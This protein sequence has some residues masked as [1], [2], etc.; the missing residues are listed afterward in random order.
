MAQPKKLKDVSFSQTE[1]RNVVNS[2][3]KAAC[4]KDADYETTGEYWS[5]VYRAF[6]RLSNSKV[7]KTMEQIENRFI[8]IAKE[9]SKYAAFWK[10]I[11]N[12]NL[13]EGKL[14]TLDDT[15]LDALRWWSAMN[16]VEQKKADHRKNHPNRPEPKVLPV[17]DENL[18][19]KEGPIIDLWLMLNETPLY[20][21]LVSA[22]CQ[23]DWTPHHLKIENHA[24]TAKKGAKPERRSTRS[25]A[26]SSIEPKKS[27]SKYAARQTRSASGTSRPV[28][29]KPATRTTGRSKRTV[30][31]P[32]HESESGGDD[33]SSY[34]ASDEEATSDNSEPTVAKGSQRPT[35]SSATR[36][37]ARNTRARLPDTTDSNDGSA[38]ARN[39]NRN[40]QATSHTSR[41]TSKRKA[42]SVEKAVKRPSPRKRVAPM[43]RPKAV[44][45]PAVEKR[46]PP[47][48]QHEHADTHTSDESK[49]DETDNDFV[50]EAEHTTNQQLYGHDVPRQHKGRR[51][52]EL[53]YL[54]NRKKIEILNYLRS[55]GS[56]EYQRCHEAYKAEM[57]KLF[58][59][60]LETSSPTPTPQQ[61]IQNQAQS[62]K[63]TGQVQANGVP[64]ATK[65]EKFWPVDANEDE[66]VTA[67]RQYLRIASVQPSPDYTPIAE[68]LKAQALHIG[69]EYQ[70]HTLVE[71]KPIIVLT[72]KG[73]NP[74]AKSVLLNS[75][76]DVVPVEN[77]KWT[78]PPFDAHKDAAGRIYA[79]GA[80]DMKCVGVQYLY[81]IKNLLAN[82]TSTQ[83]LFTRTLHISFVPDEEIGG[84]DGM[85][86]FCATQHFRNLNV[87]FALD[88]GLASA[89]ERCE[90]YVGE[91]A[92]FWF[93][94][95]AAGTPGHGSLFIENTASMRLLSVLQKFVNLRNKNDAE[96]KAN[97]LTNGRV[98]SV[99]I[100]KINGGVQH[101]V[102]PSVMTAAVDIRAPPNVTANDVHNLIDSYLEEGVTATY[103]VN[104]P[105]NKLTAID[106]TNPWWGVFTSA[107][108]EAGVLLKEPDIFP[109]GTDSRFLRAMGIPTVGFSPISN[110]PVLLHDHDEYLTESTY[111][112]GVRAYERII[113]ALANANGSTVA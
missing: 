10:L 46:I 28:S 16:I 95:T 107:C 64:T 93:N 88:E 54:E 58:D 113:S 41:R 84:A 60:P 53:S 63:S 91:R 1:D 68:F 83:P 62:P 75:H 70:Q 22:N 59:L 98:M 5:A 101:N 38:L 86:K 80:Q 3:V 71:G 33:G 12:K 111:L 72:L 13:K 65:A 89:S 112:D 20:R 67:F 14:Q 77:D 8:H 9:V 104:T 97:N 73:R 96:R 11:Y 103:I 87:G 15:N 47:P 25:L 82:H 99:N 49:S 90:V 74:L 44:A 92:P 23:S 51:A 30:A 37:S 94:L 52:Y 19:I 21:D 42:V 24:P 17:I 57:I 4:D 108:A 102:V 45:L 26:P 85:Q 109:G 7:N 61:Q 6:K 48:P 2:W 18:T 43:P 78:H 50:S 39:K 40:A 66:S 36:R 105:V 32:V 106:D 79:R 31:Q 100:T 56:S 81:A 27:S 69:L 29:P 55:I 76:T 35:T 34:N 110:T